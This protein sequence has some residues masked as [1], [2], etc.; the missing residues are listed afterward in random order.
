M[1]VQR[2]TGSHGAALGR[3]GLK[4]SLISMKNG[5]LR[6]GNVKPAFPGHTSPKARCFLE[7]S[8]GQ[9]DRAGRMARRGVPEARDAVTKHPHL[10]EQYLYTE[11]RGSRS[12]AAGPSAVTD[13][14]APRL[15]Y[16]QRAHCRAW[17]HSAPRKEQRSGAAFDHS[18]L[19]CTLLLSPA[20][21]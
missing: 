2:F 17:H 12:G 15:R 18:I 16:S 5:T 21:T 6:G 14:H 19:C 1:Y 4:F 8:V 20:S 11:G 3:F 13:P 10:P 9:M 7:G